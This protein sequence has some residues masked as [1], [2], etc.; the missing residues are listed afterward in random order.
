MTAWIGLNHRSTKLVGSSRGG[1]WWRC[2]LTCGGEGRS[3]GGSEAVCASDKGFPA[4]PL[5]NTGRLPFGSPRVT[6]RDCNLGDRRLHGVGNASGRKPES[7]S[8]PTGIRM[9][10]RMVRVGKT[11]VHRREADGDDGSPTRW[12]EVA[13]FPVAFVGGRWGTAA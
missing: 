11:S 8:S 12:P 2:V 5:H 6:Q 9:S 7:Q 3:T 10:P 1:W 13:G 4:G